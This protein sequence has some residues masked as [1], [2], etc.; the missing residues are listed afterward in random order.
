[1]LGII[2]WVMVP[3]W[4]FWERGGGQPGLQLY[5]SCRSETIP[6]NQSIS[7][8]HSPIPLHA[9]CGCSSFIL[10][11]PTWRIVRCYLRWQEKFCPRF[12][13]K[14]DNVKGSG[15][16]SQIGPLWP[17]AD[18]E[19]NS[20]AVSN[21]PYKGTDTS[22]LSGT[23]LNEGRS[24]SAE[25][26][27]WD[28]VLR[29]SGSIVTGWQLKRNTCPALEW[30]Q[31]HQNLGGWSEGLSQ[32]QDTNPETAGQVFQQSPYNWGESSRPM[33][34]EKVL[35]WSSHSPPKLLYKSIAFKIPLKQ[36]FF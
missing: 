11:G 12:Q 1:M 33:K 23:W 30:A 5:S 4:G 36:S 35:S 27:A 29:A 7:K 2:K 25:D 3:I 6:Q 16:G 19:K 21:S 18:R 31:G 22:E 13:T 28:V 17:A 9:L 26:R 32:V 24:R 20:P 15:S 10:I 14:M 34:R 8:H